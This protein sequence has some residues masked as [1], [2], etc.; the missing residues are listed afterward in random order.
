M[1]GRPYRVFLSAAS[2]DLKSFRRDAAET[3]NQ[4]AAR[5][6]KHGPLKVVSQEDFP[7]D[8]QTVWEILRQRILECDAVICLVGYAYGREPRDVP[9]GF[10][11]R[12]YTQM[13]FDIAHAL[14]KPVFLF[15]GD[16]PSALD[17]HE[18]EP[19]E[20]RGLQDQFRDE[21][22]QL[23]QVRE[24]FKTKEELLAPPRE[25]RLAA[26]VAAQA[27]QPAVSL[28]GDAVQGPGGV[29]GGTSPQAGWGP[30]AGRRRAGPPGDPRP[31]GRGQ[32]PP[33]RRVRLAEPDR[34]HGV[35]VRH[36]RHPGQ[37]AAHPG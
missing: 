6:C 25:A 5:I 21:L 1:T 27:D 12:S 13:E 31:G 2:L 11:R 16:D 35:A 19:E 22:R 24:T 30:G 14:S 20:L 10:R 17:R 26:A 18:P 29:P 4:H 34:I 23:D 32:D 36:G 8:Y 9:P 28:A 37:P 7:P 33:G 15:R 3:L